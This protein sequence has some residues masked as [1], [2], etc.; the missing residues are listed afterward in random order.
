MP[1]SRMQPSLGTTIADA[2]VEQLRQE[3]RSGRIAPGKRLR[4]GEVA[5]RFGVSTTPVREAFAALE[6]EGV[7]VGTPHRGVIVFQPTIDDLTETYEIRIPLETLATEL[8]VKRMT[9]TDIDQLETVL[10]EMENAKRD[11]ARYTNLN[12]RFHATIY[13]AAGRPKLE[14]LIT[15]LRDECAAY[16]LMW[17]AVPQSTPEAQREHGMIF[18]A[19]R[20]RAPKRA[21]KLMAEHLQ[22]TVTHVS[23]LLGAH[24]TSSDN[25]SQ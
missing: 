9:L 25:G 4:Q 13:R 18:E 16:L 21:A 22:H 14:R 11:G 5:A 7:L 12:T 15:D 10:K 2:L 8:A 6:R 23:D 20:S 1:E 3:I 19:C 17:S 24:E